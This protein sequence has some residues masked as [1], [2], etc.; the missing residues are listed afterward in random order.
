MFDPGSERPALNER[1]REAV[2]FDGPSLLVVA[3]AGTGKTRTLVARVA[4]LLER[5]TPA[6]RLMLLTFTRRAA[7]EMLARVERLG[8]GASARAVWGGTF[9][10]VAHRLLRRYG[11]AVG[12][13]DRFTVMDQADAGEAMGLLRAELG[14]G[15][16][17]RRFPRKETLAAIYSRAVN[18][19]APLSDVLDAHFPWCAAEVDDVRTVFERYTQLKR[20]R[21]LLDLDDLLLYWRALV[22]SSPASAAVASSFSHVLVDEYQDTNA[23]QADILVGLR[24]PGSGITAV[25]DDAQAIYSFRSATVENILRFPERHPGTHVIKLE[26]NYRS[27][28]SILSATNAVIAGARR[29]YGK[30]LWSSEGGGSQPVLVTCSDEAEQSCLVCNDVLEQRERGIALR[31]QAVLFRAG[32]HSAQLELELARRDIPFVKYGGLRFTEAAHVKDL[33]ACLRVLE[34]PRDELAWFRTLGLLEG[35]GPA[36]ARRALE[37]LGATGAGPSRESIAPSALHA[38]VDSAPA[39][40]AGAGEDLE[41]LRAALRDCAGPPEPGPATQVER[42]RV[43]LDPGLRRLYEAPAARVADI[44]QLERIAAGYET[45]RALLADLTLDPPN[46]AGEFAGPPHLDEDL[47]V[48]STIHSAKGME[49]ESVSIIHAADG[50][51]PC[52]MALGTPEGVDEELRL[53]YVAM[54]RARRRLNVF[55][56]LRYYHRR[57]GLDDAHTLA[58]LTR[59]IPSAIRHLFDQRGPRPSAEDDPAAVPVAAGASSVEAY[60][61]GLWQG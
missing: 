38:F 13:P 43:F 1:Q 11:G 30:E 34:N 57:T 47:L 51:I 8:G 25:G 20:A 40:L 4:H 36:T 27:T 54:T 24:S 49:W 52:D 2:E 37:A 50:M 9:H 55:F 28:R 32:H 35:V 17:K 21:A 26:R 19:A 61:A 53:L 5:G 22:T 44:E 12:L 42:L 59:F 31:R 58:Q 56:P 7:R 3:G 18:S 41:R 39:A 15:A 10:S 48:L 14:L 60:L 6:E 29:R 45:R 23:I 16:A 33:M 46:S